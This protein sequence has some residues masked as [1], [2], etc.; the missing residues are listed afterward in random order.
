MKSE[1][2]IAIIN[3]FKEQ[4]EILEKK[5]IEKNKSLKGKLREM[6]ELLV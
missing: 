3:Q 1:D 5:Y 4:Y 2:L 6:V